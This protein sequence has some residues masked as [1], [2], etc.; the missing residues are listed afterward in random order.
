RGVGACTGRPEEGGVKTTVGPAEGTGQAHLPVK[1]NRLTTIIAD[2]P[3]FL[4]TA[5]A[6]RFVD[7]LTR[8]EARSMLMY[9]LGRDPDGWAAA[10]AASPRVVLPAEAMG[11]VDSASRDG[12]GSLLVYL[13]GRDP[14]GWAAAV[15][16]IQRRRAAGRA[17]GVTR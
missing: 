7:S 9:L 11:S 5:E 2:S 6:M 14:D 1:G 12:A 3:R 13:L 10:S 15:G 4:P 16:E 8:D 17:E